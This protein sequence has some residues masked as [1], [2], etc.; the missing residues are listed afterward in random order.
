MKELE[1]KVLKGN[2]KKG[3]LIK[4]NKAIVPGGDV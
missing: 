1:I 2:E 4:N 3:K